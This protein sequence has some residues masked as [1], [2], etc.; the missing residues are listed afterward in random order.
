MSSS[1]HHNVFKSKHE[2]QSKKKIQRHAADSCHDLCTHKKK[3]TACVSINLINSV[4]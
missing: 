3:M 2:L 4:A 1:F